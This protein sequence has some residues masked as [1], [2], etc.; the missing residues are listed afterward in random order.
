MTSVI[1]T[2]LKYEK[3]TV[4]F[5]DILGFSEMTTMSVNNSQKLLVIKNTI[6][7]MQSIMNRVRADAFEATQFSDSIVI[8]FKHDSNDNLALFI[9]AISDLVIN[10]AQHS[11]L[12]RGGITIGNMIHRK[13][14]VFGPAMLEAY[15]LE[16]KIAVYPRIIITRDV[17]DDANFS[18]ENEKLSKHTIIQLCSIDCD[19]WHYIDFIS[20]NSIFNHF[21]TVDVLAKYWE[22]L[23]E[24][25]QAH[26]EEKSI[27]VKNKYAWLNRKLNNAIIAF[28]INN[29][30]SKKHAE[31][32]LALV[33]NNARYLYS[34]RP[35]G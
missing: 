32:L 2:V 26:R 27:H 16:S 33:K 1:D 30:F 18:Q 28:K 19:G 7:K 25:I 3:R 10:L 29:G 5:L 22:E 4:C 34:E 14:Y 31:K 6:D 9:I 12:L 21:S 11:I 35:I 13:D 23:L 15:T 20:H 8:S 24:T 17:L